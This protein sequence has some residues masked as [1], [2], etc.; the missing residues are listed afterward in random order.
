MWDSRHRTYMFWRAVRRTFRVKGVSTRKRASHQSPSP[1]LSATLAERLRDARGNQGITQEQIAE[2]SG[3]SVQH[4]R[5]MEGASGNPTI[6]SLEA[7]AT[8]LDLTIAELVS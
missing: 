1:K 7:V 5:R 3:L 2:K 8:A 4:I 6:G